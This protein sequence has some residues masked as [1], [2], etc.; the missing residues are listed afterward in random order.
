MNVTRLSMSRFHLF[1]V[2]YL[3]SGN[4]SKSICFMWYVYGAV[5]AQLHTTTIEIIL[6]VRGMHFFILNHVQLAT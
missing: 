4:A 3:N 6:A 5:L 2:P 1:A